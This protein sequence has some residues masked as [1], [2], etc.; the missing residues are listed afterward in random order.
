MSEKMVS[1]EPLPAHTKLRY[2]ECYAKLVLE[3]CFPERFRNIIMSD[4]PDLY[5]DANGI[6]IEVTEAVSK[7]Q[8]EAKNLWCQI[9]SNNT[10]N[11]ERSIE[12]MHQLNMDYQGGIQMWPAVDYCDDDANLETYSVVY[13]AIGSKLKKLN[14][15]S[16]YKG[17]GEYHLF[18]LSYLMIEKDWIH[19]FTEKVKALYNNY[20]KNYS[21]IY[22]L[23]QNDL[24]KIDMN[25]GNADV[26]NIDNS[27]GYI[28][29]AARQ[30]VEC[31]GIK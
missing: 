19:D 1:G 7:D 4:K 20:T 12:R 17:C 21:V 8:A 10:G 16:L 28:A 27:Q 6:G 24:V 11:R 2:E 29:R 25:N 23:A 14:K 3:H 22:L 13:D 15:G 30:M 31:G 5:D 18:V 9:V 26:K